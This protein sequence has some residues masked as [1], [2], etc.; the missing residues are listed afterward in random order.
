MAAVA[1]SLHAGKD[2]FFGNLLAIRGQTQ[3]AH[4]VNEGSGEIELVAK[5]TAGI[6][7]GECVVV[8]VVA[9]P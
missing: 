5:L 1:R 3:E 4:E 2:H 7:K 9:F 6:V 8:V